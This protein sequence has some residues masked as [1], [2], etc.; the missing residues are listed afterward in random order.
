[1]L[2]VSFIWYLQNEVPRSAPTPAR[3]L[4]KVIIEYRTSTTYITEVET[5]TRVCVLLPHGAYSLITAAL[6]TM[7]WIAALFENSCNYALLS[8][9]IVKDISIEEVPYLQVGFQ[10]YKNPQLNINTNTW[11]ASRT[12]QCISY[13]TNV[14]IDAVWK[15]SNLFSFV[16]LVLGGGATFYLWISTC[17]RFSRGSWR[18]AGYEVVAACFFQSLS[19][20]WFATDVCKKNHCRLSYGSKA[21]MLANFFW[22]VAALM[23]F[24]HYP[25]PKE[26]IETDGVMSNSSESSRDSNKSS[27]RQKPPRFADLVSPEPTDI[28]ARPSDEMSAGQD[29]Q[30]ENSRQ[31]STLHKGSLA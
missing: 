21:D 11:Y 20:L 7:G 18:W 3:V 4:T 26:L 17:C 31:I 12:G 22:F 27:R 6:T 1:V 13:P 16:G 25:K 10:A 29:S 19:F 24:S 5:M 28:E 23:I 2:T 15:I 14:E 8:G 30:Q 9:D